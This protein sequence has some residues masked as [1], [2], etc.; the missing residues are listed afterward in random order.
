[1]INPIYIVGTTQDSTQV[2]PSEA[3]LSALTGYAKKTFTVRAVNGKPEFDIET[4]KYTDG[5][6]KAYKSF[7][8]KFNPESLPID[9]P[10]ANV[11]LEDFY[12]ADLLLKPFLF[13]DLNGYKIKPKNLPNGKYLKVDLMSYS[14]AE[15][16]GTKGINMEFEIR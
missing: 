1:M 9:F 12:F 2:Y 3:E 13:I 8:L 11:D 15:N 7:T 16:D 4:V 5:K 10:S 6:T 14:I